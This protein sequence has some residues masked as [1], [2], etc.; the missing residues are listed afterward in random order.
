[1]IKLLLTGFF[2]HFSHH[3]LRQ[4]VWGFS[5][6]FGQPGQPIPSLGH[7]SVAERLSREHVS[8]PFCVGVSRQVAEPGLPC[9]PE[10]GGSQS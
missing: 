9:G 10:W 6:L 4:R 5:S 1:M 3:P 2:G 8:I 7:G